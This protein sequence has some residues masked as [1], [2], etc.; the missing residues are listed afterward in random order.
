MQ[1]IFS[2]FIISFIIFI[3]IIFPIS[4]F[5]AP[6]AN[7]QF[8]KDKVLTNSTLRAWDFNINTTEIPN[9]TDFSIDILE[10]GTNSIITSYIKTTIKNNIAIYSTGYI[11]KPGIKYKITATNPLTSISF[12]QVTLG[13]PT[14]P[15]ITDTT[16]PW[17]FTGIDGGIRGLPTGYVI[18]DTCNNARNTYLSGFSATT[19]LDVGICEQMTAEEAQLR[20]KTRLN[21]PVGGYT[22]PVSSIS[23]IKNNTTYTLLAPIPGMPNCMDWSGENPNCLGND[24]GKYLNIIFKLIIGVCIAL[25]VIMLIVYGFLY[26]GEE[27]VFGKVEAKSKMISAIFGLI[28]AIGAWTLLNTINPALTGKDGINIDAINIKINSIEYISPESFKNITGKKTLSA[29]EYDAMGRKVAKEMGIPF[30]AIRVILERESKGNPGA[31]GFDE[32][33]ANNGIPSRRA[34]IN[35]GKK[36]NGESFTPS[37]VLITKKDFINQNKNDIQNTPGLG[38]D[39]RFSK[40]LGLTQITLF[41][42]DYFNNVNYTTN[43]PAL[44]KNYYPT[45]DGLTPRDLLDPEKNLRAGASIW[46]KSWMACNMNIYGAWVGYGGG[47]GKCSTSNSFLTK[48]ATIRTEYYNGC[49]AEDKKV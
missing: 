45:L 11:L 32:N 10:N 30:C 41:P 37:D 8:I 48:E 29:S 28:I 1:K 2:F 22:V 23:D 35:S 12:E 14:T 49:S 33:V 16:T 15:P 40:G 17:W 27:S 9:G 44:D 36:Y 47:P 18:L 20:E 34:F 31:I 21:R 19:A 39:W 4:V 6:T 24:I 26:M 13:T 7:F 42:N 46:K 3:N 38:I 25:A 43:P 5:A